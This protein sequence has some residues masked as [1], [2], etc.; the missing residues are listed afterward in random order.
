MTV[1]VVVLLFTVT[2]VVPLLPLWV[3]SPVK[4]AVMEAVPDVEAVKVELQ[5]AVAP[6]PAN[7][8]VVN[9]PVTPVS[10]R[11]TV[12]E[13]VVAVPVDVSVTVTV[14]DEPWLIT[15]GL[16]HVTLVEVLRS[17]TAV[18]AMTV[19]PLLTSCVVSPGYAAVIWSWRG[20]EPVGV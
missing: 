20:A 12:P 19:A 17:G 9:E 2:L 8:Q 6:V 13:G 11:V 18:T 1:V 14:H 16:V 7:V 3:E 5:V 15:T 10:A 4:P